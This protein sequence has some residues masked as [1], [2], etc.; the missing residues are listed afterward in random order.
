MS[1]ELIELALGIAEAPGIVYADVRLVTPHR[2]LSLAVR[3]GAASALTSSAAAGLGVRV[4][5]SRAWGFGGTSDL[6][7]AGVRSAARAAVRLARAASRSAT[8]PLRVTD[9]IGP[10]NGRYASEIR[11]DPFEVPSEEVVGLLADAERRLHVAPEVKSGI[12]SFQAWEEA[13]WFRS[14]EGAAYR[15]RIVHVGAGFTA[16]AIRGA[17]VQRRSYPASFGGDCRQAGFEF[18]RELGLPEHAEAAGKEA[19]ALLDAPVCPTARTTLV[20]E[21]SQLALQVHESVGHAVELDRIFGSEA[22]YA[23]TSWVPAERIG[24]LTYGSRLMNVTADATEP[25]G[26]GTFGWDDEGVAAQQVPIVQEGTLVGVLSSREWGARLGLP[27]SGG[28]ARADGPDR[29]PLIRMTN[30]DLAPGDLSFDELLEEVDEGVYLATNRSWSIDDKRLNF[31]FG[32]EIG[33]RIVHGELGEL[34]RNPIYA[35]MT[36][37]FWGSMDAVGDRSTWRLWGVPNCGKGQPSQTARVSH[38]APVA[39]FRNVA[40]RGG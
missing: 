39:R 25:G 22:A 30:V 19:V 17:Q 5:T 28:T 31:Q 32:T 6:T 21:S 35:G 4:R 14:S 16:T 40:V 9:D 38:G 37:E 1:E 15:S 23:G 36:P 13:K 20:L 2:Y 27:R 24:T 3:D 10:L 8:E 12:A 11:E 26:L 18:I 7:P 33:R 34:V 29:A